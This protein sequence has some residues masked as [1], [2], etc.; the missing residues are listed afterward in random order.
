MPKLTKKLFGGFAGQATL[1]YIRLDELE[2]R[3]LKRK[4]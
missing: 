2:E 4:N 3:R 1:E